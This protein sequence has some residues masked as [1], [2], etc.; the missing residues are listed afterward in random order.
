MTHTLDDPP[1]PTTSNHPAQNASTED[2]A[3]S[4]QDTGR[5]PPIVSVVWVVLLVVGLGLAS[6]ALGALLSARLLRPTPPI[7]IGVINLTRVTR[8]IADAGPTSGAS[9]APRFDAAVKRLVE[10][11]PGLV[12]FVKEAV[13]DTGQEDYTNALM[14]L[15]GHRTA[16]PAPHTSSPSPTVQPSD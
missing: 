10:A 8:A 9:F 1:Q 11:E 13:I 5:T 2:V 7:K 4:P 15:F 12:L 6:G 16:P 14:P 3:A